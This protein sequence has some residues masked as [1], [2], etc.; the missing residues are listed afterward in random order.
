MIERKC[1]MLENFVDSYGFV[2]LDMSD[3]HSLSV[4]CAEH[5]RGLYAPL[6]YKGTKNDETAVNFR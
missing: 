4:E 3:G 6:S 2:H 1:F 5:G